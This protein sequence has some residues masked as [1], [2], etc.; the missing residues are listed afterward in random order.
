[1]VKRPKSPETAEDEK[2]FTVYQPYP[3]NVHWEI[4]SDYIAFSRWIAACIGTD[5]IHALHYKPSARGM[6]LI[7]VDK[8]YPHNERLLGE[9]RWKEFLKSPTDEEKD[10]VT[11]IFHSLYTTGRQAQKDGWKRI[12]VESKW[13]KDWNPQT[14]FVDPYPPTYWCPTPP[15][16]RTNKPLCRPLPVK[17][18]PPPPKVVAPVPGSAGWVS[19]KAAPAQNTPKAQKIAWEK[20]RNS[21]LNSSDLPAWDKPI[22]STAPTSPSHGRP[23]PAP[24]VSGAPQTPKGAWG[25]P[26]KSV[27]S[28]ASP[29]SPPQFP[30]GLDIRTTSAQSAQSVP[31]PPGLTRPLWS[32]EVESVISGSSSD[33]TDKTLSKAFEEKVTVTL[34]PSQ[35]RQLYGLDADEDVTPELDSQVIH[36]WETI[37]THDSMRWTTSSESAQSGDLW[38]DDTSPSGTTVAECPWHKNLCKKGLCDW[39]AKRVKEE[40]R[41]KALAAKIDEGSKGGYRGKGRGGKTGG[42]RKNS[43]SSSTVNGDEDGNFVRVGGRNNGGGAWGRGRA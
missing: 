9:H 28:P 3:L 13:F 12:H 37:S 38:G 31:A 24:S 22:T 30:P 10:R 17:S 33:G 5:P 16:D 39:R 35:D 32:D 23:I 40:E 21:S 26:P 25:K 19:S 41:V 6:V 2:Y 34:S 15:E 20:G 29:T 4:S 14:D 11:Q 8:K 43:T 7:E 27:I 18:K 36:P 1:M 42:W